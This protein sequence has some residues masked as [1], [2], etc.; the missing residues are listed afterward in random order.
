M[1][2]L[3]AAPGP[4]RRCAGRRA[5]PRPPP[6]FPGQHGSLFQGIDVL[7]RVRQRGGGRAG[8]RAGH[9]RGDAARAVAVRQKR[10]PA[11]RHSRAS[12]RQGEGPAAARP[13]ARRRARIR[14]AADVLRTAVAPTWDEIGQLAAIVV[15]RTLLNFFC[16][17]R[18][19]RPRRATRCGFRGAENP[20]RGNMHAIF[21]SNSDLA[22][23]QECAR[24][25]LIFVYGLAL[26]RIA[27]GGFSANGRRSI[28]SCRS[29][30]GRNLSRTLTGSAQLWGTLAATTLLVALHWVLARLAASSR[31]FAH[32]RGQSDRTGSRRRRQPRNPGASL[33]QQARPRRGAAAIGG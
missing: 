22:W 31:F 14:V 25:A 4:R 20:E 13:L 9:G 26:V 23:Y 24:A 33:G 28:S 7:A 10:V 1:A 5:G 8:D 29:S 32:N 12:G 2:E 3:A 27:G 11:C 16:K 17:R 15:L 6:A 30:S 19:I 18:S 21:G